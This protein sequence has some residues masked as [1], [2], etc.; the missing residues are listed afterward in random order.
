MKLTNRY[1]L[2]QT[3]INL[4]EKQ[5]GEYT[6]TKADADISVTQLIRSPRIDLP[7]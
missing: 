1:N 3:L 2:P 7:K 4:H 5:R 6:E